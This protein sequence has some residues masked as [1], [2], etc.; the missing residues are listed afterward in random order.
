MAMEVDIQKLKK[1]RGTTRRYASKIQK[2]AIELM[3]DFDPDSKTN[4]LKSLKESILERLDTLKDLDE[5]NFTRSARRRNR[6]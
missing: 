4:K 6:Q 3:K 5:K 1:I 2:E